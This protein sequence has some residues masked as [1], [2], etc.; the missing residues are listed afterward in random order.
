MYCILYTVICYLFLQKS[1]PRGYDD[2]AFYFWINTGFV[3]EDHVTLSRAELD[4]PHKKK[5]W[6]IFKED[7]SVQ[8]YFESVT[9]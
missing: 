9:C 1:L 3:D 7:F 4:N 2:C 5:T 8:I 6:H